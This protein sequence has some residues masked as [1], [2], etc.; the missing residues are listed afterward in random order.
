MIRCAVEKE[1]VEPT[2]RPLSPAATQTTVTGILTTR[3]GVEEHRQ[4]DLLRLSQAV[5][6]EL[7]N[8]H[9]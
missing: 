6:E 9:F 5:K 1:K 4:D 3:E 7:P 8:A 2:S